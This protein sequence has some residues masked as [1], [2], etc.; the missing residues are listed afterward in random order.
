MKKVKITFEL[1]IDDLEWL[2]DE[3]TLKKKFNGDV[4]KMCKWLYK[5]DFASDGYGNDLKFKN[6]EFIN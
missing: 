2:C 4:N 1:V 6:A 5:D 3:D